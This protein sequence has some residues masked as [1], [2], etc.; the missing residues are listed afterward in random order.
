LEIN[1]LISDT[2]YIFQE[3]VNGNISSDNNKISFIQINSLNL[4]DIN[5]NDDSFIFIDLI[6]GFIPKKLTE[7]IETSPLDIPNKT[8]R[9]NIFLSF[10]SKFLDKIWEFWKIRCEK[11]KEVDESLGI[12]RRIKKEEFGKNCFYKPHAI[13]NVP[14]YKN[15][16]GLIEQC[17]FGNKALGFMI[18]VYLN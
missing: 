13:L 5:I 2:K 15:L 3:I 4:W 9:L 7:F 11:M 14:K 10:R 18:E 6:K 12:T 1:T 8:T 17:Y 16:Y